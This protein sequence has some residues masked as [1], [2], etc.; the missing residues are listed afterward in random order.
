MGRSPDAKDVG[1]PVL[2]CSVAHATIV[3]R[4]DAYEHEYDLLT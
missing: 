4:G 1:E 3:L 2:S